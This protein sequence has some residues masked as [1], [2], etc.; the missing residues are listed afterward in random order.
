MWWVYAEILPPHPGRRCSVL[1]LGMNTFSGYI[2]HKGS[3]FYLWTVLLVFFLFFFLS[4]ISVSLKLPLTGSTSVLLSYRKSILPTSLG[5][6][7][8]LPGMPAQSL[9]AFTQAAR[10]PPRPGPAPQ[11]EGSAA[12][13]SSTG[14]CPAVSARVAGTS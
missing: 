12:L 11:P 9:P 10:G 1:V 2:P 14:T 7:F 6:A 13:L 5:S 8:N 3:S 4:Q